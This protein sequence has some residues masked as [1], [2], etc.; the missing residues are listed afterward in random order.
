M[1][2]FLNHIKILFSL[3][4]LLYSSNAQ[5]QIKDNLYYNIQPYVGFGVM[6]I[7]MKIG[8]P[9]KRG[10][11]Q[12]V[13]LPISLGIKVESR[14]DAK[15]ALKIDLN[16]V[17]KGVKYT[18]NRPTANHSHEYEKQHVR[19]FTK[20]RA[21]IGLNIYWLKKK[22]N[23]NYFSINCGYKFIKRQ[24]NVDNVS[25]QLFYGSPFLSNFYQYKTHHA[26]IRLALGKDILLTPRLSLNGEIGIGGAP[27]HF[28]LKYQ[29]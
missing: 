25:A 24:Y 10:D 8:T 2:I 11:A 1:N 7:N 17:H 26:A 16:Y 3:I 5:S 20:I 4:I 9:F 23:T 12:L 27:L 28:G 22:K 18:D 19:T 15:L 14:I 13:G 29:F 6:D 21:M